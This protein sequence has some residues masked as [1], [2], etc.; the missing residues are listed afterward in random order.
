MRFV[1]QRRQMRRAILSPYYEGKT[2]RRIEHE[3]LDPRKDRRR[4]EFYAT[5]PVIADADAVEHDSERLCKE[6]LP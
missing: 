3:A 1:L 2:R 4:Q 5:K 6:G